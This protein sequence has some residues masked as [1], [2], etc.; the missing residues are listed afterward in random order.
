[1]ET[2]LVARGLD[3]FRIHDLQI[4]RDLKL[5]QFE[6]GAQ[7]AWPPHRPFDWSSV[8]PVARHPGADWASEREE[9]SQAVREEHERVI[10]H[11][12]AATRAREE[13]EAAEAQKRGKGA[14]A[15]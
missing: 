6:A 14:A 15:A 8:A 13:R 11:Y 5:P 2:E 12:D 7:L 3:H 4:M 9:R 1:L 10:A